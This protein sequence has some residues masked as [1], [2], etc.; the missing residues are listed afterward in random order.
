MEF[1]ISYHWNTHLCL[2]PLLTRMTWAIQ[3]E[4]LLLHDDLS[5]AF[6]GNLNEILRRWNHNHD[7]IAYKFHMSGE[8]FSGKFTTTNMSGWVCQ[9]RIKI[10]V[11]HDHGPDSLCHFHPLTGD[12]S[13]FLFTS[14][15]CSLSYTKANI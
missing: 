14:H 12:T 10:N 9:I 8:C 11:D 1:P 6:R 3:R 13:N 4:L 15:T 5:A 2:S 7:E